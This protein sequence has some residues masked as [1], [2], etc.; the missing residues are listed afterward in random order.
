MLSQYISWGQILFFSELSLRFREVQIELCVDLC[1][2][3]WKYAE[4]RENHEEK[5]SLADETMEA[6][7][8]K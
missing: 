6:R 7:V 4:S 2:K 1:I 8:W 5:L 3:Y